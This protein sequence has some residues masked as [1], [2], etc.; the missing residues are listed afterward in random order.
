[1]LI[2][3]VDSRFV[4]VE[5]SSIAGTG[6]LQGEI[7]AADNARAVSTKISKLNSQAKKMVVN[8]GKGI[9]P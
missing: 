9:F 1:M 3:S 2:R 5:T 7:S 4:R 6:D 8:V